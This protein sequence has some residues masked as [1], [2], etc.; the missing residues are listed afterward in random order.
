MKAAFFILLYCLTPVLHSQDSRDKIESKVSIDLLVDFP[1]CWQISPEQF[2]KAFTKSGMPLFRWLTTGQTRAIL[3]RNLYSNVTIQLTLFGGALPVEEM[4][5]D[6]ADEKIN[7]LS[8]SL[9]NRGDSGEISTK[10]YQE[11]FA[12]AKKQLTETMQI[13]PR[14]RNADKQNGLLTEGFSWRSKIMGTGL[15][16][17]NEG[18]LA[19]EAPEFL[20]LRI[21]RPDAVGRLAKGLV[22]SWGNSTARLNDLPDNIVEDSTGNKVISPFPMIDQGTKGYCVAASTQRVF[23]Y[24]G[25][26]AD[27][28][29]IAQIANSDPQTGTNI[30]TIAKELS[31]IDYRFKT[32]LDVICLGNP[33]KLTKVDIKR[34]EYYQG[35]DFKPRDFTKAVM[36]MIDQGI[37]ILWSLELGISPELPQL[38]PQV[39]GGHMRLI[40]GYNKKEKRLIFSDSWGR[41]HESKTMTFDDAYLATVGLFTLKPT[42]H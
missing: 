28:H 5:V 41:G 29:Q 18:A 25:I 37:P 6:F 11:R 9:Y 27:M 19:K 24:Y 16:E 34:G 14:P 1:N 26:G 38:G 31:A 33:G 20:R 8:I 36:G 17:H 4:I 30:I 40:I 23:E 13:T 2:E 3:S 7:F 10:E 21:A 32:R 35:R 42:V 22:D 15:L 12:V 39:S